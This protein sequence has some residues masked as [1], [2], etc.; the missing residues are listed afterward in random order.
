MK[1]K[2]KTDNLNKNEELNP[3]KSINN[4]TIDEL[5]IANLTEEQVLEVNGDII[6]PQA[7]SIVLCKKRTKRATH[8]VFIRPPMTLDIRP[9]MTEFIR[10]FC[11]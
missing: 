5:K 8:R 4:L 6:S 10:P 1:S 2:Y 11:A 9:P 3:G 7:F